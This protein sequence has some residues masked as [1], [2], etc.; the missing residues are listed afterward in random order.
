M[1]DWLEVV[2][3]AVWITGLAVVLTAW[4]Y[5]HWLATVTRQERSVV[6][7]RRSWVASRTIGMAM[8]AFGMA[9][10]AG[11]WFEVAAWLV[12]ASWVTFEGVRQWPA[13][14]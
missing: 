4:S 13:H 8:F 3:N 9:M 1:I 12:L 7:A 14:D 10:S 5:L 6:F 11:R 2:R